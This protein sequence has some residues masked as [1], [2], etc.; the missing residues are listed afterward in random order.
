MKALVLL[1]DKLLEYR[2]VPEPEKLG[3]DS[4]LVRV[5]YSGICN[6]DIHR[7][8]EGGAYHYPLIMGHEFSGCVEESSPGSRFSRGDRVVAYPLLPCRRCIPCR[9]GDFAQC[10]DY[11]Y[12]G[13]RRNG[14]FA[15]Y[16]CVPESNLFP[17]PARV[18]LL[19]AA[20]TEPCAVAQH[21]VNRL[22]V[23]PG[24]SG[25]V[26]GVGPIG[27]MVAQLLRIRGCSPIF[28]VDIQ[29]SKLEVAEKMGFIP[30]NARLGDPVA[31]I[32]E[33][34]RGHGADR[35]VEAC[36]LPQTFLQ[37]IKVAAG[38]GEIVFLG[39][40]KGQFVISQEDFSGILRRELKIL[41][42]WNSK[43]VPEGRNDWSTV[44]EYLDRRLDVAP[45]ISRTPELREGPE[46][47]RGM[48]DKSL[49]SYSK[50][51]FKVLP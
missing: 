9:S 16:V 8:F 49:G 4:V 22:S 51:I 41:G 46:V 11:D 21:G 30:I 24:N 29:E 26:F 37:V 40:I 45:L 6:S 10:L 28:T 20:L 43:I 18:D 12:F 35:V 48:V 42:T 1:Q 13:S 38:S 14:G 31:A 36:G 15:E 39:N 2:D 19:H 32:K 17:V 7:G 44:L 33:K 27:N 47:F 23:R 50:V 25:A 3:P 5:A 34:T